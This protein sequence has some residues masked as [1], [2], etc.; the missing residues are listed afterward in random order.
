VVTDKFRGRWEYTLR[1]RAGC[2]SWTGQLGGF[3]GHTIGAEAAQRAGMTYRAI[4]GMT[5]GVVVAASPG[6][7]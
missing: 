5:G 6:A 2:P 4:D 1:C 7:A 3:T